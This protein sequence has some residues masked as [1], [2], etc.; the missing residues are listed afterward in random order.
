MSVENNQKKAEILDLKN[1]IEHLSLTIS[2]VRLSISYSRNKNQKAKLKRKEFTLS[3]RL[4]FLTDKKKRFEKE[5][6]M[7]CKTERKDGFL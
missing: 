4:K 1:E 5:Y 3:K 2:G 7:I 6:S